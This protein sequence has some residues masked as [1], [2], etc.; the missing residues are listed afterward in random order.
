M[1][2]NGSVGYRYHYGADGRI[3]LEEDLV[4]LV[5]WRYEY[6][7]AGRILRRTGTNGIS[8]IYSYNTLGELTR[9]DI[10]DPANVSPNYDEYT[11]SGYNT[12]GTRLLTHLSSD[13]GYAFIDYTYDGFYRVTKTAQLGGLMTSVGTAYTFRSGTATGSTSLIPASETE[14][15]TNLQGSGTVT[16]TTIRSYSYDALGNI[17]TVSEGG[18]QKLHYWYDSLNQLVRE[19]NAYLNKTFVY[20]YDLGGN[21]T[22]KE[23]YAYQTGSTVSGTP[24]ATATYTYGDSNWKDKLTAFNGNTITY[25]AIGNPLNYYNGFSFTWTQ[26]RKLGTA[27]NGT[28]TVGFT[29]DSAGIRSSKTVNGVTTEYLLEGSKVIQAKAGSSVTKYYYDETGAPYAF[30]KNGSC[31]AYTKN[32]QGD[33]AGIVGPLGQVLVH[34]SYDAWG[35]WTAVNVA[36]T[37]VAQDLIDTNPFLYRGYWYDHETGL[38]YLQSRYYD[39]QTG[40]FLNADVFITTGQGVL[41]GNMFAYCRNTP[42]NR[43]DE[44]GLVD[45]SCLDDFI[46]DRGMLRLLYSVIGAALGMLV[47]TSLARDTPRVAIPVSIVETAEKTIQITEKKRE[48]QYVVYLLVNEAD[49]IKYVG[50]TRERWLEGRLQ[51]HKRTK[52]LMPAYLITGLNY[53]SARG[54]E[55]FLMLEIHTYLLDKKGVNKIRGISQLNPNRNI[56]KAFGEYM[57]NYINEAP[58]S[59]FLDLFHW[60]GA[61]HTEEDGGKKCITSESLITCRMCIRSYTVIN[62]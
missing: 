30:R 46:G 1:K 22:S 24:T 29:Y 9:R 43:L 12:S 58:Y 26:G 20:S 14:T 39:P 35:N 62:A 28:T 10:L 4:N 52:G 15:V 57:W 45:L 6:D 5:N 44:T 7:E 17:E 40:R 48:N 11:Y 50:R 27:S 38:Y 41:S 13:T 61:I 53:E 19:D 56:Y 3:G 47:V 8:Y 42:V 60:E 51:F 55:D 25:D 16:Q 37:T 34:Y 32:I 18:V 2:Y 23:E 36:G 49:E 31:Y 54:L 21:I 59:A 33:I